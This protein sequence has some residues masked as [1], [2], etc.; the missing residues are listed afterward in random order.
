[1]YRAEPYGTEYFTTLGAIEEV[2]KKQEALFQGLQV[3]PHE[4]LGYKNEMVGYLFNGE[5]EAALGIAEANT[6]YGKGGII[7]YYV[8]NIADCIEAGLVTVVEKIELL[9]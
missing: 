2:G 5:F 7:Q 1:M 8:P 4:T 9:H 6:Q 3:K